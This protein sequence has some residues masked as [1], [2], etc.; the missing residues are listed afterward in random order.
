MTVKVDPNDDEQADEIV[1]R[2]QR[3]PIKWRVFEIKPRPMFY[4]VDYITE[5]RPSITPQEDEISAKLAKQIAEEIDRELLIN[6]GQRE[7]RTR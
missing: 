5:L 7:N 1:S 2:L 3:P 6:Y 4:I